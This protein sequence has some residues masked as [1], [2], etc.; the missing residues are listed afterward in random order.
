MI[1]KIDIKQILLNICGFCRK[2]ILPLLTPTVKFAGKI[3][4]AVCFIILLF[5]GI[6]MLAAMPVMLKIPGWAMALFAASFLILLL[7]GIRRRSSLAIVMILE[8]SFAGYCRFLTPQEQFRDVEFRRVFAVKPDVEFSGVDG[9]FKV[10]NLRQNRYPAGY[11]EDAPYDDIFNTVEFDA[12]KVNSVQ[13]AMVYWDNMDYAAHTMLNF[14]FSD[15][16]ELTVSVEPRTPVGIDRK[17]FTCLCKQQELLF[18]LGDPE[19]LLDLRS[20]IR[21]EDLYLFETNFTAGESRIILEHILKRVHK[22]YRQPEFYDLI[23]ANCV[24][25]WLPALKAARPALKWDYRALF[26][27]YFD[28]LMFEQDTL[29]PRAGESFESLKNRS[30]VRGKSCGNL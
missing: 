8:L 7:S 19:D 18:I 13:L 29:C 6:W 28:R 17:P 16:K 21:G 5:T 2:Y 3:L 30:F 23:K 22:L 10:I 20:K 4:H 9:R 24:T 14:K 27:G 1:K 25:A 12:A 15:G 26:N 11:D